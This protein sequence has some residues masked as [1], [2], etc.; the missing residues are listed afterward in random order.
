MDHTETDMTRFTF[1]NLS[2]NE[3]IKLSDYVDKV[4][5]IVNTASE[6]GLT[7]QYAALEN[8]YQQFKDQGLVIIGVPSGDFGNQEKET[9]EEIAY[10]CQENYGVS[11]IL[12]KKYHI[13]GAQAHPFYKQANQI[14]GFTKSPKWN[15]HKYLLNKKGE[16]IDYFFSLTA[17]DSKRIHKAITA[18]LNE[19]EADITEHLT[20]D[21]YSKQ[22]SAETV[23]RLTD[24][25]ESKEAPKS[26][27]DTEDVTKQPEI[28]N[29]E[30]AE[31]DNKEQR[32]EETPKEA[33]IDH[34]NNL[35]SG[36]KTPNITMD[37]K[38]EE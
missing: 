28:L 25:L 23:N 4:V 29:N 27:A 10:F 36:N 1:E 38:K 11:F 8:L 31:S 35:L 26:S 5:L 19:K 24:L 9:S 33:Q 37:I 32:K 34:F 21:T 18:I 13:T 12:T 22:E 14:M 20:S 16:L 7:G 3:T 6:C 17:P 30:I 15:F 2:T